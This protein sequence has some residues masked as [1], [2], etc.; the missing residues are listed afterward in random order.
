MSETTK[1]EATF[2]VLHTADWH[3]GKMLCDQPRDEEHR[4]FL[5]FLFATL[6]DREVDAL[7]ISGDVFDSANPPQ[8]AATLYFDFLCR[9]Y[10]ETPCAA[11]IVAGNHD[12]PGHLEAPRQVLRALRGHVVG[13]WPADP[14]DAV[15]LLPSAGAPALAI[16]AVP[17]L[18]DRD[19]RT[20]QAG[21]TPEE[22]AQALRTGFQQRYAEA[23]HAIATACRPGVAAMATGHLMADGG[24]VSDSE[25]EIH[26]GGL[27]AVPA[28]GFPPG[29]SYIALGHLH[30][31]QEIP[32]HSHIR[33]AGSPI[34]LGF[35]ESEDRK[36]VR[37]LDFAGGTLACQE[38]LPVPMF[39]RLVRIRSPYAALAETVAGVDWTGGDL[40]TWA[41]VEIVDPPPGEGVYAAVVDALKD[42]PCQ[43]IK[44]AVARSAGLAAGPALA[45]GQEGGEAEALLGDPVRVFDHR[46]EQEPEDALPETEREAL[47][48]AFL[49]LRELLES[50]NREAGA[51]AARG[52]PA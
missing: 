46:M 4:R 29:F 38:P 30:R 48:V 18:R 25:R 44:V 10:R 33:Y 16:A 36:E 11:V 17:F 39:R 45:H 27:G 50:R 31:P 2:R 23:N 19:L 26:V 1:P 42:A 6:R 15:I 35:G 3:L 9:L 51:A 28:T 40:K 22:I 13:A 14:A 32:G 41:E 34:P 47:R 12:S 5:D 37:L 21:Q 8:S 24:M 49:E 43:V 7:V 20:G 52:G